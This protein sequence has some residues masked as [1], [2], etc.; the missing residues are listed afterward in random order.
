MDNNMLNYSVQIQLKNGV[1]KVVN[2][3]AY[4]SDHAW[5]KAVKLVE[6]AKMEIDTVLSVRCNTE[7]RTSSSSTFP[8]VREE[9]QAA[10]VW[11]FEG[12]A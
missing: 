11:D 7:I 1:V 9:I 3:K 2:I 12:V 8:V 4:G 6:S 10:I 5:S